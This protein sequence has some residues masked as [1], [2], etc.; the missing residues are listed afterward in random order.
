MRLC[1]KEPLNCENARFRS[2]VNSTGTHLQ[3]RGR[4]FEPVTA[5]DYPE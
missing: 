3:R 5:H 2:S 1:K 4:R